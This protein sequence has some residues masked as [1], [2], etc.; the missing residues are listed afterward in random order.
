MTKKEPR[1]PYDIWCELFQ[2][3]EDHHVMPEEW[4]GWNGA[5]EVTL[6]YMVNHLCTDASLDYDELIALREKA[7]KKLIH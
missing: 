4:E 3:S 1:K 7:R 6:N 2:V 5:V